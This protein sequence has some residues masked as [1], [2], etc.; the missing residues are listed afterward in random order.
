MAQFDLGD[1]V[2]VDA[3]F[4]TQ[5][6]GAVIDPTTVSVSVLDPDRK[7][8]TYVYVTDVEVVKDA[9]GSYYLRINANKAGRWY[10]R[11]FSTGTGQAAGERSFTVKKPEALA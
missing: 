2:Q 6:T 9:T 1:L 4:T 11:W 10:Y 3:D 7:L 5:A 8:T